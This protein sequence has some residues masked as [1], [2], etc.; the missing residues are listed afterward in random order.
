ML[1]LDAQSLG[2]RSQPKLFEVERG[3]VRKFAKALGLAD[4]IYSSV[5]A[6]QA[7]GYRD[8][9]APPTFAVTLL[10][11]QVPGLELPSA[12][13]LHGEQEFEWG[14]PLC[15]GDVVE[16]TGWVD[17]VKSRSSQTGKMSMITVCSEGRL[18]TGE[19]A[20]SARALLIVTEEAPHG[21]R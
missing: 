17:Q 9:V 1:R 10:P 3:A 12:G 4:S 14:Q 18:K 16:V 19:L 13:V 15:A 6:A 8:L 11:W 2:Q 20:F 5:E 21:D 7:Q